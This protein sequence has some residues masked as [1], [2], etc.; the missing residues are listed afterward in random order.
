M[1]PLLPKA[2][3]AWRLQ[4][5]VLEMMSLSKTPKGVLPCMPFVLVLK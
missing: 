4:T 5:M 1:L 3:A 2:L